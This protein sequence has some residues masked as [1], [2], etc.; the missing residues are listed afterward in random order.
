VRLFAAS[1]ARDTDW[2]AKLTDVYPDGRSMLIADGILRARFRN[3]FG[4]ERLLKPGVTCEFH[5]DLGSTS[6]VLDRGHRV[7]LAI[8]CSNAP[9]YE[10]NPNTG[11]RWRANDQVRTAQQTVRVGDGHA[12]QV[13]LP[14]ANG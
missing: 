13:L 3:G 12:S 11:A 10:P 14:V 9:R 2:T 1:T 6:I 5:I 8:S 7:R 4:R